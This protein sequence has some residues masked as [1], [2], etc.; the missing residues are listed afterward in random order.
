MSSIAFVVKVSRGFFSALRWLATSVHARH[1]SRSEVFQNPLPYTTRT[2]RKRSRKLS[3]GWKSGKAR[4][5]T[6]ERRC[7][8]ERWHADH[9]CGN[10]IPKPKDTGTVG[11]GEGYRAETFAN[12]KIS[13]SILSRSFLRSFR[14]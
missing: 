13:R 14:K 3:S 2:L 7:V 6:N 1:P 12:E 5:T 8:L 4:K 9:L 10:V 11:G